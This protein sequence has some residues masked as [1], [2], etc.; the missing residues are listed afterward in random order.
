[1]AHDP[2]SRPGAC[3]AIG[4]GDATGA[5]VA[6]RFAHAGP[7]GI[8]HPEHIADACGW[9]RG[10]RRDAGTFELDLRPS[11]EPW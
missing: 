5:T 11:V 4:A 7:D 9:M 6:M 3:C 1:M 8:Q 2:T 10:L